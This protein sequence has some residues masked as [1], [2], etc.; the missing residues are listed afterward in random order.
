MERRLTTIFY[1]DGAGFSRLMERD[2][3]G[4]FKRLKIARRIMAE[5]FERH[6]GRQVN[7]WGD[8]VIAEFASVVEAV[9]CAVEIQEALNGETGVPGDGSLAARM[10][11]RIGVNLG[12]VLIDGDDLYGD[13]VNVAARLQELAAPGGI[14]ISATVHDLVRKQLSVEFNHLG[15]QSVKSMEE[16]VDAWAVRMPKTP[17]S[18]GPKELPRAKLRG[19]AAR[20]EATLSWVEAQPRRIRVAATMI[21]V[22]FAINLLF[23][24][25]AN[26]WFIFPSA[27]FA[28]MILLHRRR[29]ARA[30]ADRS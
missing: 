18:E 7:S 22:F 5:M 24:G 14:A 2:E 20:A 26:P 11:F 9:R 28:V 1:A 30:A 17:A 16:R 15:P 29:A 3:A 8:A 12:D 13:G 21:A 10:Q 6:H 23:G 4:V 25:I 27:P 19:I